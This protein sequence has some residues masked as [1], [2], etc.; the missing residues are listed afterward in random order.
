VWGAK[1]HDADCGVE[2]IPEMS[3]TLIGIA[4]PS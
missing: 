2:D 3:L 1:E 4:R